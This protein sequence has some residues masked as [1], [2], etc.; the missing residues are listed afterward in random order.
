MTLIFPEEKNNFS[1]R[2]NSGNL[3]WY[4]YTNIH[5]TYYFTTALFKAYKPKINSKGIHVKPDVLIP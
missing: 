1:K 5:F 2:G 4:V 3:D